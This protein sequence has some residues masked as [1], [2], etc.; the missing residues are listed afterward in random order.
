MN[1]QK[2]I[3]TQ[4]QILYLNSV[5]KDQGGVFDFC[6]RDK[7]KIEFHDVH[8]SEY[9]VFKSDT[10]SGII[11]ELM[12]FEFERGRKKGEDDKVME[13]NKV[14]TLNGDK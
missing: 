11:A 8:R 12:E 2:K 6:W 7:K 14:L 4:K 10:F 1:P 5:L 13:F 3:T 9:L